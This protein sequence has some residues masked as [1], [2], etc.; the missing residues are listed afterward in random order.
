MLDLTHGET[1]PTSEQTNERPHNSHAIVMTPIIRMTGESTAPP[2]YYYTMAT[3]QRTT[4]AATLAS[5]PAFCL[6]R[7]SSPFSAVRVTASGRYV[8]KDLPPTGGVYLSREVTSPGGV[9]TATF[10][11]RAGARSF[12]YTA[13]R[14]GKHAANIKPCPYGH[15][16]YCPAVCGWRNSRHNCAQRAPKKKAVRRALV[17]GGEKYFD[18][19]SLKTEQARRQALWD[20]GSARREEEQKRREEARREW[21]RRRQAKADADLIWMLLRAHDGW[22][23][24]HD[25][26]ANLIIALVRCFGT[27]AGA[28]AAVARAAAYLSRKAR[29]KLQHALNGNIDGKMTLEQKIEAKIEAAIDA[30]IMKVLEKILGPMDDEVATSPIL[31]SPT[32]VTTTLTATPTP[33]TIT[34]V[35]TSAHTVTATVT[36]EPTTIIRTVHVPQTPHALYYMFGVSMIINI[37]LVINVFKSRNIKSQPAGP[38]RRQRSSNLRGLAAS[39]ERTDRTTTIVSPGVDVLEGASEFPIPE[40]LQD[41]IKTAAALRAE[42]ERKLRHARASVTSSSSN[43]SRLTDSQRSV[44]ESQ[45]EL[46]GI[47]GHLAREQLKKDVYLDEAPNSSPFSAKYTEFEAPIPAH[48]LHLLSDPTFGE[49]QLDVVRAD[50]AGRDGQCFRQVLK[51]LG[52]DVGVGVSSACEVSGSKW[53]SLMAEHAKQTVWIRID[54]TDA[55]KNHIALSDEG[56]MTAIA[57][58]DLRSLH[59]TTH[60]YATVFRSPAVPDV[61]MDDV[62]QTSA[63]LSSPPKIDSLAGFINLGDRRASTDAIQ[64]DN[65]ASMVRVTAS[66]TT[67]VGDAPVHSLLSLAP[68][69]IFDRFTGESYITARATPLSITDYSKVFRHVFGAVSTAAAQNT[70]VAAT[71]LANTVTSYGDA[72]GGSLKPLAMRLL[73]VAMRLELG[74]LAGGLAVRARMMKGF[75]RQA[76]DVAAPF[77]IDAR[78]CADFV[79][80]DAAGLRH[81]MIKPTQVVLSLRTRPADMTVQDIRRAAIAIEKVT[82]VNAGVNNVGGLDNAGWRI[83]GSF[84]VM[85]DVSLISVAVTD[86]MGPPAAAAA[87]DTM[88][89]W[90]VQ[91]AI[92]GVSA[93]LCTESYIQALK[94]LFHCGMSV[95]EFEDT[96]TL[97]ADR[98]A[99]APSIHTTEMTAGPHEIFRDTITGGVGAYNEVVEVL[100]RRLVFMY[101]RNITRFNP[102]AA[103]NNIANIADRAAIFSQNAHYNAYDDTRNEAKAAQGQGA[104]DA[105]AAAAN[106]NARADA[107]LVL[108]FTANDPNTA[109]RRARQDMREVESSGA[110]LQQTGD[111]TWGAINAGVHPHLPAPDTAYGANN[112]ASAYQEDLTWAEYFADQR[113][114]L[115]RPANVANPTPSQLWDHYM[116]LPFVQRMMQMQKHALVSMLSWLSDHAAVNVGAAA[117]GHRWRAPPNVVGNTNAL[118][119]GAGVNWGAAS[120]MAYIADNHWTSPSCVKCVHN[121]PLTAGLDRLRDL[122]SQV[123]TITGIVSQAA[124]P[125][126][127]VSASTSTYLAILDTPQIGRELADLMLLRAVALFAA[128]DA[129]LRSAKVSA[130]TVAACTGTLYTSE[131]AIDAI[132]LSSNALNYGFSTVESLAAAVHTSYMAKAKAKLQLN[133]PNWWDFASINGYAYAAFRTDYMPKRL[134]ELNL[135]RLHDVV[136]YS[137]MQEAMGVNSLLKADASWPN[138]ISISGADVVTAAKFSA[139]GTA[140]ERIVWRR[141]LA[142]VGVTIPC[143]VKAYFDRTVFG[144]SKKEYP[145]ATNLTK[146]PLAAG[147]LSPLVSSVFDPLGHFATPLG[148]LQCDAGDLSLEFGEVQGD[149]V[150]VRETGMVHMAQPQLMGGFAPTVLCRQSKILAPGGVYN[151]AGWQQKYNAWIAPSIASTA[152][153]MTGQSEIRRGLMWPAARDGNW[154]TTVYK[155]FPAG[156]MPLR[157]WVYRNRVS[158]YTGGA[159]TGVGPDAGQ[160][161]RRIAPRC[162]VPV[163]DTVLVHN[164]RDTD[165]VAARNALL[166]YM[167][168]SK[169]LILGAF[170]LRGFSEQSKLPAP[171]TLDSAVFHSLT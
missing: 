106:A 53:S 163:V 54:T 152:A 29:N 73:A 61:S 15:G 71:G 171:P 103:M 70:V 137:L 134:A 107:D 170:Q 133:I 20:E 79:M 89:H 58:Q 109:A 41:E 115:T 97:L 157:D 158:Y 31:H 148:E 50:A 43:A 27:G 118:V 143:K 82:M 91:D 121:L 74:G 38:K 111:G 94:L 30:K 128:G 23:R 12:G 108:A 9:W 39:Q 2:F 36:S 135:S 142:A 92:N 104:V 60:F 169:R 62:L 167:M 52:C 102:V 11:D 149:L 65:A 46:T 57:L 19:A 138:Q 13:S 116:T 120:R 86:L 145:V 76:G 156:R 125:S 155:S 131:P 141:A 100:A 22:M 159:N 55:L 161:V 88:A 68:R 18:W 16:Y 101:T 144:Q 153:V 3:T 7:G 166:T 136:T 10:L 21:E 5:N 90:N 17:V 130:S 4:T 119:P 110:I 25:P 67:K 48:P 93:D 164:A 99:L 80:A 132:A 126:A 122:V 105:A 77:L 34:A 69:G 8:L 45:S 114:E 165:A 59:A 32:T 85:P 83:F 6:A 66:Q 95:D 63:P 151:D 168:F 42:H 26:L 51:S 1:N 112:P 37:M 113:I 123:G 64:F 35:V 87:Q 49:N 146:M 14:G 72:P 56:S 96:M 78:S 139:P 154:V 140:G 127:V 24:R 124:A 160:R 98:I 33:T 162:A 40:V 84:E 150:T 44:L 47:V 147:T 129:A 117:W 75:Q 81:G 28:S